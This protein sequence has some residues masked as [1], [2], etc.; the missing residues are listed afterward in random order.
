MGGIFYST[1]GHFYVI[2]FKLSDYLPENLKSYPRTS[3]ELY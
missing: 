1:L 3:K 2:G